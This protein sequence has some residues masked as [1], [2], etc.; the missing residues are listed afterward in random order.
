MEKVYRKMTFSGALGIV[1]G[2]CAI[3][4]GLLVIISGA[5]MLKNRKKILF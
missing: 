1:G 5:M 4:I 3:V 2:I